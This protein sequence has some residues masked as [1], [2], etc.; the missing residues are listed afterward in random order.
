MEQQ[1]CL[2]NHVTEG[3]WM[4]GTLAELCNIYLVLLAKVI[5]EAAPVGDRCKIIG[6]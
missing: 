3:P 6:T 1:L 2:V 5:I 4:H